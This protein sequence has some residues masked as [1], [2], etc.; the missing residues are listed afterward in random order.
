MTADLLTFV[1]EA[2]R[3]GPV[4]DLVPSNDDDISLLCGLPIPAEHVDAVRACLRPLFD[5][6]REAAP[7][8]AKL[9][10]TDAFRDGN[11]SWRAVAEQVRKDLFSVMHEHRIIIIYVAR[12]ARLARKMHKTL[13]E[14]M[15]DA[16]SGATSKVRIVGSNRPNDERVEDNLMTSLALMLDTF[17]EQEDR[18]EVD[19]LFDEV[20]TA[21]ANRYQRALETTRNISRNQ[22]TVR[23]WDP[24]KQERL[25]RSVIMRAKAP[26]RLDSR[27][28]GRIFVVGKDD[29]LVF[30]VDVV[31][32]SLWRHLSTLPP[33]ADLNAGE[34]V[35]KWPIGCLVWARDFD[36]GFDR[37]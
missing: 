33:T 24:D 30:A 27:F 23:G 25:S 3:R 2:G 36:M 12:R 7:K 37:L 4:R 17:A 18:K 29:P 21:V 1:D 16:K 14:L 19:I 26:F 15:S 13:E 22:K 6:F 20:D 35:A 10:I 5:R 34:S 11:E 28:L 31:A 9:H 8:N 32:N